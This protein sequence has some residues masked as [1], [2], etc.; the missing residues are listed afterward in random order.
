MMYHDL[1]DALS[2]HGLMVRGG[3]HPGPDDHVPEG[4]Q[5]LVLVGNAGPGMWRTF[6]ENM[7]D[8]PNPMD[9]WSKTI[10]DQI[11]ARFSAAAAYP[12]EGPPYLPFQKWAMQADTVFETPIGPL[13][14]PTYGMWHAYRGAVMFKDALDLPTP[15]DITSPCDTCADKPCLSTCPVRAFTLDGYDVPGCRAH[16][17]SDAG[18]DC[19]ENGCLARR[20]CPIGQDYIYEPAQAEFHMRHFLKS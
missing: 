18:R 5:T 13:I 11:A 19:L 9:A 8:D 4:I 6:A 10:I 17:G 20:A 1:N 3:F 7:P 15:S 14:H 12:F 2:A 16:I